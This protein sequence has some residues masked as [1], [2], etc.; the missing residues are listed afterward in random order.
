MGDIFF[1]LKFEENF[2]VR[3]RE[4]EFL[5]MNVIYQGDARTLLEQVR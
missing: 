4:S 2:M 1:G 5:G 3:Q